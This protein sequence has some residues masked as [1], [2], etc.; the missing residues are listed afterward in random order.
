MRT[1]FH[2]DRTVGLLLTFI[3]GAMDSYTYIQYNAFASAQTG[4][5]VLAIIQGFDGEWVSVGKKILSTLF[6]FLGILLTKY[7]IDYFKKKEKH[8][9]RLFVLYYE[10]LVF[11][12]VSL[13]PIHVYPALVTI[14]ISFTAAIQWISFDKINGRAYTN[15]FTTGNLKG[16]ATNLYDFL[17]SKEKADFDRF[18]H[19]LTV[20][21]SFIAG[22]VV[23]VFCH[24]LFGASSILVVSILFLLLALFQSFQLWRFYK[25]I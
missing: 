13:A 22:A 1:S 12:L 17:I 4:N 6:F 21:L 19:Y 25:T 20:V 10:A 7:L 11:F 8:F 2:E 15:L 24:H 9:W 5:I 3:G 23:L 18:F 16:V 14:L